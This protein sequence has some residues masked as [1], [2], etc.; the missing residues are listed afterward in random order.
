MTRLRK[1]KKYGNS[2]VIP[3]SSVDIK[4]FQINVGDQVDVEDLVI[5]PKKKEEKKEG[6]KGGKK[7]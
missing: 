7:K 3:L 4:D 5:I 6:K 1:I 2:W